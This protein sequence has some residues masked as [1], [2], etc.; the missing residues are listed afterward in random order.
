MNPAT[1]MNVLSGK[2]RRTAPMHGS[3]RNEL[4]SDNTPRA[5]GWTWPPQIFQVIAWLLY[6][7][8]AVVAFGMFIPLLPLPWNHVLYTFTGLAFLVHLLSHIAAISIDPADASVRAKKTYTG[9]MPLFDRTVQLHV[10]QDFHC[11]LCEVKVGPKVKHCSICNKCVSDFD[12]HC[13]WLNNCVGGRN[14]GYFFAAVIS[15]A[16]GTGL[17]V[18]V[19]LFIFIQHYLDPNALRTSPQFHGVMANDTWLVFLP[20]APIKTSSAGLLIVAFVTAMLSLACLVLLWHLLCFHLYL[21]CKGLSTYEYVK[22]QRQKEAKSGDTDVGNSH[23]LQIINKVSQNSLSSMDCEPTH[24]PRASPFNPDDKGPISNRLPE[25]I[26]TVM[27]Y[28]KKPSEKEN[29]FH[30]DTQN[31][32]EKERESGTSTSR[33]WK[34]DAGDELQSESVKSAES[35][36]EVQDHLGSLVMTPDDT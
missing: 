18:A 31:S 12:H 22:L 35:V 24:I 4:V 19:V 1:K 5:N 27:E 36:P 9:P 20:S 14:Y 34:P 17:L 26:C 15:A 6:N 3:S 28:T 32:A 7:Y 8:L 11:Y 13:K 21:M 29:T 23:N 30:H 2:L 33:S 16:V 10:I 25:P